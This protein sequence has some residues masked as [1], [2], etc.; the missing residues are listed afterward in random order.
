MKFLI[1]EIQLPLWVTILSAVLIALAGFWKNIEAFATRL[2]NNNKELKIQQMNL[3][4][5]EALDDKSRIKLLEKEVMEYKLVF[6]AL[7]AL[8]PIM[9]EITN[10]NPEYKFL[11]ENFENILKKIHNDTGV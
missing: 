10:K 3:E 11:L 9:Q 5:R 2:A 1:T 8:L 4:Q 6:A 7:D